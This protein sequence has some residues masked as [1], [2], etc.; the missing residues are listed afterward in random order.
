MNARR[1]VFLAI[2]MTLATSSSALCASIVGI[3]SDDNHHPVNRVK[4]VVVNASRKIAG[5]ATTDLYGWYCL[6]PLRR[7]WYT[8]KLEPADT[9]FLGGDGVTDL[10]EEG[11]TVDWITSVQAPAVATSSLGVASPATA[12][13]GLPWWDTATLVI[14]GLGAAGAGAGILLGGSPEHG[15]PIPATS[16]K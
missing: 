2:A 5:R 7:G 8:L 13:C 15:D 6:G 10:A 4:I 1:I 11:L 12:T 16:S 3:V 9:G 14:G